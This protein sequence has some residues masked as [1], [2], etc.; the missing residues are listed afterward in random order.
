ML[1]RIGHASLAQE[2]LNHPFAM[3]HQHHVVACFKQREAE[4]G[5]SRG[6]KL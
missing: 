3:Q 5:A 6:R 2:N 1:V 4:D